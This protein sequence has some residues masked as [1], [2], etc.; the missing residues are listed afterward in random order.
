MKAGSRRLRPSI[1]PQG[2]GKSVRSCDAPVACDGVETLH[3]Q[4]VAVFIHCEGGC[5]IIH[6]TSHTSVHVCIYSIYV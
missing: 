6:Y 2:G 1:K 4:N 5:A 3:L